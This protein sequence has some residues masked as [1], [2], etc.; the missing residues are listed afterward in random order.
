M[1]GSRAQPILLALMALAAAAAG[2]APT[3][4]TLLALKVEGMSEG[5]RLQNAAYCLDA[6]RQAREQG[7]FGS[8]LDL[9]NKTLELNSEETEAHWEKVVLFGDDRL[10][11]RTRATEELRLFLATNP[12]HG[13]AL[14]QLG[15]HFQRK[16][17]FVEAEEQYKLAAAKDPSDWWIWERY[18]DLLISFTDRVQEG[19]DY[20]KSAIA[21]G[22]AE[23]WVQVLLAH[24][25]IRLGKYPD[26]R[27]SAAKAIALLR[28]IGMDEQIAEMNQ[29]LHSIEGK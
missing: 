25:Y 15:W 17:K 7:K 2:A 4:D 27:A 28:P 23:P 9:F 16:G 20:E 6:G 26:A 18:G 5:E 11:L 29:L 1:R 14:A 8:A 22:D 3:V 12:N 21:R 13:H 10:G 19:I 24:G